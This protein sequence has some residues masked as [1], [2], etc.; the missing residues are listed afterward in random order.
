[1][2]SHAFLISDNVDCICKAFG[3]GQARDDAHTILCVFFRLDL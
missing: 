1:M 2:S 3:S